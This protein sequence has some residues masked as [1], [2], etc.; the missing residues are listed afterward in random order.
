MTIEIQ[1]P[2]IITQLFCD[3]DFY[4]LKKLFINY[5]KF[6]FQKQFS[7][8]IASENTIPELNYYSC[9]LTFLARKI[10]NS[11]ELLPTYS[12]F[13]HYE[14]ESANLHKHKD[15]NACT[16]TIDVCIYQ[17]YP[18]KIYVENTPYTLYPNQ[19]LAYYG[20]DQEHWRERFPEPKTNYVAMVFF[21]FAE[22]NHWYFTHGPSYLNSFI[23]GKR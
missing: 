8:W 9:S 1:S 12:L 6:E 15:D 4:N 22:P 14:G 21:H 2:K 19:A 5:K 16:Y 18:W 20:N 10:F 23:R 3:N 7:R 17:K 11:A 13:A